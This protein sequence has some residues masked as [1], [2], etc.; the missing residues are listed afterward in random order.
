[1]EDLFQEVSTNIKDVEYSTYPYYKNKDLLSDIS[2]NDKAKLQ[3][4]SKDINGLIKYVESLV[5]RNNK[6]ITGDNHLGN[7]KSHIFGAGSQYNSITI[8]TM[9]NDNENSPESHYITLADK[10]PISEEKYIE[11]FERRSEPEKMMPTDPISQFYLATLGAIGLFILYR[12]MVK[13]S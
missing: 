3:Q 9:T 5:N 4:T 8:E 13:S 12:L 6:D 10:D 7:L 1:M 11:A 2:M